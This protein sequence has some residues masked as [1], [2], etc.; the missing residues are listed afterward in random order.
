MSNLSEAI[1]RRAAERSLASRHLPLDLWFHAR[2]HHSGD[3]T[4]SCR[5]GAYRAV[6]LAGARSRE[7]HV[8]IIIELKDPP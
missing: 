8:E 1:A 6:R 2:A 7:P 5:D 3:A 4:D